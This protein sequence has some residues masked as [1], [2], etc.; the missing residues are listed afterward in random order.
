MIVHAPEYPEW[1][2]VLAQEFAGTFTLAR[3]NTAETLQHFIVC[4]SKIV[5]VENVHAKL[6]P[7]S[8]ADAIK[9]DVVFNEPEKGRELEQRFAV[10]W[11]QSEINHA[12]RKTTAPSWLIQRM[13]ALR[14]LPPPTS[15]EVDIQL[16][17]SAAIRRTLTNKALV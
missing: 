14:H 4:D 5:R 3:L 15:D 1:L 10:L 11:E 17:A 12:D 2:E 16:T 8:P 9:A 7:D 6:T 13:E